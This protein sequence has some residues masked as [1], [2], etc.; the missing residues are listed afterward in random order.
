MKAVNSN[1]PD[2]QIPGIPQLT[3]VKKKKSITSVQGL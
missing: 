3:M 1:E 2:M